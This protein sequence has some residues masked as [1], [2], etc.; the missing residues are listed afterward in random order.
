MDLS[1]TPQGSTLADIACP[2]ITICYTVGGNNRGN[3][4]ILKTTDSGTTWRPANL[5][6]NEFALQ[7]FSGLTG[8][9]CPSKTVCYAIGGGEYLVTKDSGATWTIGAGLINGAEV[10]VAGVPA[11]GGLGPYG[12]AIACPS[13][14]TCL[15]NGTTHLGGGAIPSGILVTA[16]SGRRWVSEKLPLRMGVFGFSCP[17]TRV[18]FAMGARGYGYGSH[19][20][21]AILSSTDAGRSWRPSLYIEGLGITEIACSTTSTCVAGEEDG[22]SVDVTRDSGSTW[23]THA[24]PSGLAVG[25]VSCPSTAV[26]YV[27]AS[28][29]ILATSDS[30]STWAVRALPSNNS[31]IA[32]SCPSPAI[33]FVI[34]RTSTRHNDFLSTTD[35]GHIWSIAHTWPIAAGLSPSQLTCPATTTCYAVANADIEVTIDSG[36]TWR[37]AVLAGSGNG[38]LDGIACPLPATC[39]AT[40]SLEIFATKGPGVTWTSQGV[41]DGTKPVLTGIACTSP[42]TC[43]AVGQDFNCEDEGDDPCPAGTL[44]VIVTRNGGDDWS[45]YAIPSDINLNAVACLPDGDC[46][47]VAFDGTADG[48]NGGGDGSVLAFSN[49]GTTWSSQTVPP[50]TGG[51]T[52]VS[53]PSGTTCFAVGEGSGDVGGLILKASDL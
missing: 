22:D 46:Y 37:T 51:L 49:F 18:C 9:S 5:V 45:G 33:C 39:Y 53:C 16:D 48:Y 23:T 13:T 52:S 29:G 26:C 32:I 28:D 20:F 43:V 47:A 44:A 30:G 8:I 2:S 6:A 1:N 35:S 21:A 50:A 27:T 38:G 14:T 24:F 12:G 41:P 10:Q 31:P 40:G 11:G 4:Y 7:S 15:T 19:E 42:T 17:S 34:A 3:P 36:G 25:E